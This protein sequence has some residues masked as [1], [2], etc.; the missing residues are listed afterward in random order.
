[1]QQVL[2]DLYIIV[3]CLWESLVLL[4]RPVADGKKLFLW[5]EVLVRMDRSLLPEG[6]SWNRVSRVGG[7]GHNLP[8]TPQ[9]PLVC[10]HYVLL[11]V[12]SWV[13]G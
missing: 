5:H 6:S 13:Q 8:R 3:I 11:A 9:G 10:S 2:M 4:K 1:M 12:A 7:V